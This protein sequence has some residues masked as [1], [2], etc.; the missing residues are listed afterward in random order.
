M[1]KTKSIFL[2]IASTLLFCCFH[3][4]SSAIAIQKIGV[5]QGLPQSA[6]R[7]IKQDKHGFI[8]AGTEDGLA[9]YDGYTFKQYSHQL[10][11]SRIFKLFIDDH[12]SL[13]V[14]TAQGIY[15]YHED[16][17]TFEGL[18][19]HSPLRAEI[20]KQVIRGFESTTDSL[21]IM[22]DNAL[23]RYHYQSQ[24][25]IK[26]LYLKEKQTVPR[27]IIRNKLTNTIWLMTYENSYAV[28]T[29][30]N[31]LISVFNSENNNKVQFTAPYL[32]SS[33]EVQFY[34]QGIIWCSGEVLGSVSACGQINIFKDFGANGFTELKQ[35]SN[36]H[37]WV[38]IGSK[39]LFQFNEKFTLI[40]HYKYTKE[41][42]IQSLSNND[43]TSISFDRQ[44]NIWVGILGGGINKI[45][46]TS[47]NF[48]LYQSST[49]DKNSLTHNHVRAFYETDKNNIWIGTYNG[50]THFNKLKNTFN[51]YLLKPDKKVLHPE[52]FIKDIEKIDKTNL[53][54][55][56]AT[57]YKGTAFW[58]FDL[59]GFLWS[60]IAIPD[61]MFETG[62][63]DLLRIKNKI[64]LAATNLGLFYFDISSG[65]WQRPDWL[66]N[67]KSPKF[68]QHLYYDSKDNLWI[69]SLREGIIRYNFTNTEIL[70]YENTDTLTQ[71]NGN[72]IKSFLE[73][74]KGSIWVGS[75]KGLMK[76]QPK[77][78]DFK[79]ISLRNDNTSETIYGLLQDK[80]DYIWASTN[81]GLIRF[82]ADQFSSN[83]SQ[84][85]AIRY[86][87]VEDGLPGNEF[88]TGAFYK[89]SDNQFYFGGTQG[90]TSFDPLDFSQVNPETSLIFSNLKIF[91][92]EVAIN[93]TIGDFTLT[94]PIHLLDELKLSYQH[95]LFSI[96]FSA[97]NFDNPN[98]VK[99]AYRLKGLFDNWIEADNTTRTATFSGLPSGQYQLQVKSQPLGSL[100]H[101]DQQQTKTLSITISP[102]WWMSYYAYFVYL[103][104]LV[105]IPFQFFQHRSKLVIKRA[106]EL[107]KEVKLRTSQL[108]TALI[109]KE[110][111]FTNIS[112]E[113]RTP[114]TLMLGP[115]DEL[116]DSK[117]SSEVQL[118]GDRIK[119][120]G[121][122]LLRL[123][124][125][126][127]GIARSE[128]EE[129]DEPHNVL[130]ISQL[131][132]HICQRFD[133]Y[134]NS[135]ELKFSYQIKPMCLINAS[136]EQIEPIISNLLS[137]AFK[138]TKN[139]GIIKLELIQ[140]DST[141]TCKISDNGQG[142][143]TNELNKI[144]ERF[145]RSSNNR[146]NNQSSG[147]GLSLVKALVTKT[148][149]N[150]KV[151]S[152]LGKGSQF[153]V[154]WNDG[155][156]INGSITDLTQCSK[157]LVNTTYTKN[158]I[159]ILNFPHYQPKNIPLNKTKPGLLIVE[160]HT[161]LNDY[162][163]TRLS[164]DYACLSAS[165]GEEG[166]A[167]AI[168]HQ[169]RVI[170][171]DIMMP[172]LDGYGLCEEIKTNHITS[173]IPIILLTA[174]AD[175]P[176]RIKGLI[177]EANIYLSKPFDFNELSLHI[178]NLLS[179][180]ENLKKQFCIA[181]DNDHWE[182][183]ELPR[184]DKDFLN[185]LNNAMKEHY[186]DHEFQA[187]ELAKIVG[188]SERQLQRKFKAF[189][190]ITPTHFIRQWRLNQS[191][192]LLLQGHPIGNI[193]LDCGFSS[194]AYFGKC[195]K[196]QFSMTPSEY[197]NSKSKDSEF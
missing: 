48:E 22:T 170:I 41:N 91:N 29:E 64:W 82:H 117:Q 142:I 47:L 140:K 116:I 45:S 26:I 178:R 84:Y 173:H 124:N 98:N 112:H 58:R 31:K 56:I 46:R 49:S 50:L 171:S 95:Q 189:S 192:R 138:Y 187:T 158:E 60:P 34:S 131:V 172:K 102:P 7:D 177:K 81:R 1:R 10:S 150:I 148:K 23:Y 97:M 8:W 43:V 55:T 86:F 99:Y 179:E 185:S 16:T 196:Q 101:N 21:W 134:A 85:D 129:I 76:Y 14:A 110:E 182:Q 154:S 30:T 151:S 54:I 105:L 75:T 132:E 87:T 197:L 139:N 89:A 12:Q 167:L 122:L 126:L 38:G 94:K 88:N 109:Q 175:Q 144:F 5:E 128:Q 18:K 67:S 2:L 53:M 163:M 96:S 190:D 32:L 27:F 133:I 9:R 36:G 74:S 114:L 72:W 186:S 68:I 77:T 4:H 191:R 103:L 115:A 83:N 194:Q 66:K 44:Q 180:R 181:L 93:E 155:V 113:F 33:G 70:R 3:Q 120:N 145:Y 162:L 121:E 195:F 13:W 147:I 20:Q 193:A 157:D 37:I 42:N 118:A 6:I 169:P 100:W 160:D 39:G 90:F 25:I 80:H 143:A 166:V 153:I 136:A 176:S 183:V 11:N 59:N 108:K 106:S 156:N 107:E 165:N 92:Q 123:V 79:S 51:S 161:E 52:N 111:V 184:E 61:E 146:E 104:M 152:S 40:S 174:K 78:D 24:F 65:L 71:L 28:N 19:S 57:P 35:H 135:T 73:D 127:L 149:G 137:N 63:F 188:F 164:T 69:G 119:R 125:Q 141:I 130:D 159:S 168:K 15:R 17:D 62:G